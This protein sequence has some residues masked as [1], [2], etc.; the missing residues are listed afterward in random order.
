[1]TYPI[2]NSFASI[3]PLK[4]QPYDPY[5]PN[6]FDEEL[7]LIG[8]MN[9]TI[10][11]LNQIG[12]LTNDVVSQWNQVV[13]WLMNDN[14][15]SYITSVLTGW[16]NDG[17][18]ATIIN[19]TIFGNINTSIANL[20][21]T[22][23]ADVATL[24]ANIASNL[25]T[26]NTTMDN[27]RVWHSVIE[28]GCKGDGITDDYA[29]MQYALSNNT[30]IWVP[31]GTYNMSA[32]LL[33]KKNT[34]FKL[35]PNAR[36]V[37]KHNDDLLSNYDTTSGGWNG[38]GNIIVE[39]GIF[40]CNG[41]N[42][43]DV[44]TG[45]SF[46]HGDGIVVRNTTVKDTPYGHAMEITGCRNVMV[47][48]VNF[49]G[50]VQDSAHYYVEAIQIETSGPPPTG[51]T[52]TYP[53][54]TD[55]TTSMNITVQN[56]R[57]DASDKN[58]PFPAGVGSHGTIFG[59]FYDNITVRN[60]H[61]IGCTYWAI[62]PFKWRNVIIDGNIIENGAGGAI[63]I[64][65][66]NGGLSIQDINHVTQ[67]AEPL[68]SFI[69]TN[70][71]V[72]NMQGTGVYVVGGDANSYISDIVIKGNV[73]KNIGT[74]VIDLNYASRVV[75]SDNSA[76]NVTKRFIDLTI[77]N[78]VDVH[79]NQFY[80]SSENGFYAATSNDFDFSNNH[81][82][83]CDFYGFNI[84]GDCS[85]FTIKG[86]RVYNVSQNAQNTY[87]GILLTGGINKARVVENIVRTSSGYLA[88]RYGLN[89]MSGTSGITHYGN[90]LQCGALSGNL[91]DLSTS[92]NT[93]GA[94]IV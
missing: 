4:L 10:M 61:F 16:E 81:I 59:H 52:Y 24:N 27:R 48:S 23:A 45:L 79:D 21:A 12:E 64:V 56:C 37:R 89:L 76:Y 19:Q 15:T 41:N 57:F 54:V 69:V 73:F 93:T 3:A 66:P 30:Y 26:V 67:Y 62:R 71:I 35:H 74:N 18:L 32:E 43:P 92:P 85:Q 68:D 34:Y 40:D 31:E 29:A 8:K 83:R 53:Y 94:N 47:D 38:Q 5:I 7:T 88:P 36:I 87:D 60:N 22:L 65:T 1:M 11:Y 78:H 17:T 28:D 63:Y 2:L 90:D 91:N 25:T 46:Q 20:T 51:A 49:L 14:L 44:G 55:G 86:N 84:S 70:N 58:T 33:I 39:G 9:K 6:A 82:N 80:H 50:F 13:D 75:C 77:A 72:S 42:Y